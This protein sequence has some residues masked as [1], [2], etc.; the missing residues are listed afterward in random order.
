MLTAQL[1]E[2]LDTC[3]SDLLRDIITFLPEIVTEEH[4]A[5]RPAPCFPTCLCFLGCTG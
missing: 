4:H 1:L 3:S 5:V 2:L